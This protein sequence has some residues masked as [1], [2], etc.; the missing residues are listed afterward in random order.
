MVYIISSYRNPLKR[1][2]SKYYH[3]IKEGLHKSDFNK[4]EITIIN[5]NNY[6]L[7]ANDDYD[8]YYNQILKTELSINLNN[9]E[10]YNKND[11]IGIYKHIK[12]IM[13]I[14]VCLEDI[15]KFQ[16]NIP[17][18]IKSLTGLKINVANKNNSNNYLTNK[19]IIDKDLK[20][21][22]QQTE[23][24]VLKFYKINSLL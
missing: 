23:S 20:D 18:Y 13:F 9:V 4:D 11:G 3:N 8:I 19:L 5:M 17:K 2:I 14:F 6:K 10:V 12:N 21:Y 16:N 15:H 22:L 1:V 7:I 24:V